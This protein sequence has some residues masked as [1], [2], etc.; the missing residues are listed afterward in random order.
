MKKQTITALACLA[1]CVGAG[2]RDKEEKSAADE[3]ANLRNGCAK[4]VL[5]MCGRLAKAL[6][7]PCKAGEGRDCNTIGVLVMK[8]D[9]VTVDQAVGTGWFQK[10]CDHGHAE[11]CHNLGLSFMGGRGVAKD[12]KKAEAAL[13]KACDSPLA[14]SCGMLGELYRTGGP[15]LPRMMLNSSAMFEKACKGGFEPACK[16]GKTTVSKTPPSRRGPSPEQVARA[17]KVSRTMRPATG[18]ERVCGPEVPK[19]VPVGSVALGASSIRTWLAAKGD[20]AKLKTLLCRPDLTLWELG[21]GL[22]YTGMA[23]V[24]SEQTKDGI[25]LVRVA[26]DAHLNPVAIIKLARLD[27]HGSEKAKIAGVGI[28]PDLNKAFF[29]QALSFQLVRLVNDATG[30][31][32]ILNVVVREGLGLKDSF[33]GLNVNRTFDVAGESTRIAAQVKAK[34]DAF[35]VL[36]EVAR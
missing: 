6:E 9:G 2:C 14:Q 31:K 1:L 22:H 28:K 16:R 29:G 24:R 4:G 27:Y 19:Q 3:L 21:F 17:S 12:G 34:V 33:H 5:N 25:A 10:G 20:L 13:K 30:D 26:A 8:G 15:G 36:Y 32:K 23:M 18:L 35:G 11:A 7:A